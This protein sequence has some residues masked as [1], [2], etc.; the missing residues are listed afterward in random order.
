MDMTLSKLRE[1]VMDKDAWSATVH[2]IT[3]SQTW[4]SNWTELNMSLEINIEKYGEASD[5]EDVIKHWH[6][7][8]S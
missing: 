8:L 5:I 4:L 1:L 3:K 2:G 6:D 7:L